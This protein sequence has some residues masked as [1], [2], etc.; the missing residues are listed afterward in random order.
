MPPTSNASHLGRPWR[1]RTRFAAPPALQAARA[2]RSHRRAAALREREG[3]AQLIGAAQ[4]AQ[5]ARQ[6]TSGDGLF[7][8]LALYGDA[9]AIARVA[10]ACGGVAA[11]ARTGAVRGE[12]A[13]I[14][15]TG[16]LAALVEVV[17]GPGG[18]GTSVQLALP[19]CSKRALDGVWDPCEGAF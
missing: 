19:P 7:I 15:V 2:S 8:D 1:T 16:Q 17:V 12:P 14:D 6:R 4:A 5:A 18:H 13:V 3:M 10:A 11:D 9:R